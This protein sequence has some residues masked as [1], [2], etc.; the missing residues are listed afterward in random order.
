[1]QPV[2]SITVLYD[3]ACGLC[4]FAK[5]WIIKQSSLVAIEFVAAGSN[6]ARRAFPQIPTGELAVVA[7]SGEVWLGN[8]AWI[9]CLWALRDYR[10]LAFRLTGPAL[11]LMAREAFVAV[12]RNRLALSSM[13]RLRNGWEIEQQ[14]RK[15]VAP[16]CQT[17]PK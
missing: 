14:L 6:E 3:A 8:H 2:T 15:V 17:G 13:L 7:D 16:Q 1:M 11:S 12:S 10:N 4:T 5:D 9:V